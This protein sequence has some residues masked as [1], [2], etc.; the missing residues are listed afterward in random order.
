M[1]PYDSGRLRERMGRGPEH[2][3]KH[4]VEPLI[5]GDRKLRV[6]EII[7]DE[8]FTAE[9]STAFRLCA[10]V[11]ERVRA[12]LAEG[13]FPIVLSGNCI[14]ALGTI[15]GC[16]PADTDVVWFD[17]HGEAMTPDTTT[18]GFLDG[19]GISVLTGHS[20]KNQARTISG[21]EP[22]MGERIALIGARDLEESERELLD[23]TGVLR[24]LPDLSRDLYVHLDLDVLDAA[25]AI[26][27]QWTPPGGMK[28][29]E[30][31]SAIRG[32]RGRIK[33]VG[34]ASYDP[35][36]DSDGRAAQA[37]SAMLRTVLEQRLARQSR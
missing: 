3:L 33:A 11:A 30:V 29:S 18:S 6:E 1:V 9:I 2:L 7:L 26:A 37:T 23:R 36:L 22:M 34:V 17:A 14:T 12:G 15:S 32:V 28:V 5:H 31:Q 27:N 24:K 16:G 4:A 21:F 35:P 10:K 19:M 8:S 25:E 13:D 20:W